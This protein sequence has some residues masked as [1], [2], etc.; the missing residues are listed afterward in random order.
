E[1]KVAQGAKPGEGG[2]LPS[3]KVT[4]YIAKLR[5]CN[6][7]TLLISPPPHHDIYSIE[8][9]AQLINDLKQANPEARICV[10]LVSELGV[11]TVAAGVA[12][13]YADIVQ[14][15]GYEGGTGAA[16]ITSIKNVG[17]YWEVGL[18]ETQR[19]LMENGLRD[20]I[21]IRVDGG[22]RTGRDV[23]IAALL[24]AEEFGFGTATMIAAGCVMARQCH[25]N[26]CPTGIATLD[27]MGVR[28]LDEITGM[29]DLLTMRTSLI[30]DRVRRIQFSELLKD[31]PEGPRRCLREANN[32]PALSMNDKLVADLM[33]FIE[34]GEPIKKE[35]EIRNLDRSIPVKLNYYISLKYRDAGLPPDTLT[36]TFRGT[37]GQSFGAFNHK[38][39]SLTLVGDAND[40]VG[41]G[42]F[43]G[44]VVIKPVNLKE[45][46]KHVILGNTVLYGATG[47]ELYASGRAGERFA[48]RNSGAIAV[49]EGA[50][51]H[52]C[53]YMTKGVVVV[54][55][56]VGYNVG[57]GMTGGVIY[58]FD[59]FD[60]LKHR[61]NT[62]YV[63]ALDLEDDQDIA[64]LKSLIEEHHRC[65]ESPRAGEILGSSDG[66]KRHFKKIV[67]I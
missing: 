9:L 5:H 65:T 45:P 33:P 67:P 12:K 44:R 18:A 10:K 20:R 6:P 27:E 40:Y 62:S 4:E 8:D 3:A 54:I 24:G 53:E 39:I 58:L 26:T 25:L 55:G 60:V 32:S 23:V 14:I 17:N 43:G 66:L 29:V 57:A 63:K 38:G 7:N 49:V 19:V 1:I 34:R 37:A 46:H 47:G 42:M 52:L 13:A 56:A 51:Q 35:Y 64:T 61:L 59:E 36:L 22:L 11:G 2:H 16:P 15:S 30:G 41:K 50:S 31:Y 21:R 48:V 28:S